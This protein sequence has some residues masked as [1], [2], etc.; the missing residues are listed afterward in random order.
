MHARYL[1]GRQHFAQLVHLHPGVSDPQSVL[2]TFVHLLQAQ[3][4]G[5]LADIGRHGDNDD[6]DTRA[7]SRVPRTQDACAFTRRLSANRKAGHA[8]LPLIG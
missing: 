3:R 8:P 7:E 6:Q 1:G 2:G 5:P 4:P